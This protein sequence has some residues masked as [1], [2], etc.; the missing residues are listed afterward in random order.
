MLFHLLL[1]IVLFSLGCDGIPAHDFMEYQTEK[2][3]SRPLELI[4]TDSEVR[5]ALYFV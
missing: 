5:S 2:F 1:P 3:R 4:Q